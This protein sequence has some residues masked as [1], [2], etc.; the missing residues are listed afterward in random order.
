M[1]ITG[2][3]IDQYKLT[4]KLMN[5]K[6]TW[7]NIKR[8][9]A[10]VC[11]ACGEVLKELKPKQTIDRR[12]DVPVCLNCA[13]EIDGEIQPMPTALKY[14][15]PTGRVVAEVTIADGTTFSTELHRRQDEKKD[16]NLMMKIMLGRLNKAVKTGQT[17]Y[18]SPSR[19]E[20]KAKN[21]I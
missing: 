8:G 12:E 4:S 15:I 5:A 9:G 17:V 10:F 16:T 14:A 21:E 1:I 11:P 2:K 18:V 19:A 20:R 6:V 13:C 3:E 7:H